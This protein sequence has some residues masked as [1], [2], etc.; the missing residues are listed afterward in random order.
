M[1]KP[2]KNP[3]IEEMTKSFT[4]RALQLSRSPVKPC[5]NGFVDLANGTHTWT[6]IDPK[7]LR[8]ATPEEIAA[9]TRIYPKRGWLLREKRTGQVLRVE[10]ERKV[11][12][13]RHDNLSR[14]TP[15]PL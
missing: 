4:D 2:T 9:A 3:K 12:V 6:W 13:V 1:W 5:K 8:P 11:L 15:E 10:A 14:D 7:Y